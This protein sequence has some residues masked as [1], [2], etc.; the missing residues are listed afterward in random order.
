[1]AAPRVDCALENFAR[2]VEEPASTF[3]RLAGSSL[4]KALPGNCEKFLHSSRQGAVLPRVE[5]YSCGT[6]LIVRERCF[7]FVGRIAAKYDDIDLIVEDDATVI[8]IGRAYGRPH[9][10]DDYGLRMENDV[11]RFIDLHPSLQKVKIVR[12]TNGDG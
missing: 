12:V 1:M 7:Q 3:S 2:A 8:E 6:M 5:I 10:V 11:M 9:A 4:E